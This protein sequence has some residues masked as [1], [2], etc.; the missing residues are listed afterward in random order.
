MLLQTYDSDQRQ[1][2]NPALINII[3]FIF[4]Q[5]K[6]NHFQAKCQKYFH[7]CP[8]KLYLQPH[9][10]FLF[11]Q[12][13]RQVSVECLER[14]QLLSK[15]RQKYADLLNRVSRRAFPPTTK[16]ILHELSSLAGR[17]ACNE[18]RENSRN[19]ARSATTY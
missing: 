4:M 7:F 11:I 17:A 9:C 12:V 15:L 19:K 1:T 6:V 3:T 16:C 18:I 10:R 8:A 13:I 2:E 14:G 5:Q